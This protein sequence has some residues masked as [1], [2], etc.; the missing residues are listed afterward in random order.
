[1]YL[2]VYVCRNLDCWVMVRDYAVYFAPEI[3]K[4]LDLNLESFSL[5]AF[6]KASDVFAFG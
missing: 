2:H 4:Q 5:N 3:I 1:M 6:T